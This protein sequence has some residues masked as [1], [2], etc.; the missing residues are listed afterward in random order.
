MTKLAIGLAVRLVIGRV[1]NAALRRGRSRTATCLK[2]L[3]RTTI[4]AWLT[5]AL[6]AKAAPAA[7]DTE[8]GISLANLQQRD[9]LIQSI[10]WRLIAGNASFCSKTR[11]SIGLLLLDVASYSKPDLVRQ[12]I[13]ING[14]IA[15]QARAAGSPAY[16]AG[17]PVHSEV[18][19]IEGHAMRDLPPAGQQSWRRLSDLHQKLDETLA[20]RGALDIEW[21]SAAHAPAV[22]TLVGV[23]VCASGFEVI[24]GS[25]RATANGRR[26]AVGAEFIGFSYPE[27]LLAAAIA[28]ELAHNLLG[29]PAWLDENG[30]KRRNIRMTEREADRLMPWLLANG[31]YDPAAAE[32]FMRAWG[33][34]NDGGLLRGRTH[35]GWDERAKFIAAELPLVRQS[36]IRAGAADW[37]QY[38]ARDIQPAASASSSIE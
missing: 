19:A 32:K 6:P 15:V 31:G 18:L 36:E 16:L 7:P 17:L 27:G 26:V 13:G 1:T 23:P 37:A 4:A 2:I 28:H 24:A 20:A 12:T 22:T 29:H 25:K 30:R 8:L 9:E 33:P 21:R 38:F 35:D 34:G 11:P 5:T 14:D 3:V 10:G